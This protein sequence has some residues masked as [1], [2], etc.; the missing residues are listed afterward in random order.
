[1]MKDIHELSKKN[2]LYVLVDRVYKILPIYENLE[3]RQSLFNYIQSLLYEF[4]GLPDYMCE[5]RI[6]SDFNILYS[7]LE[8]VSNDSLFDDDNSEIVKREIFK[9]IN[10]VKRIYKNVVGEDYEYRR[11]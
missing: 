10:L 9:S 4:N 2:Y 7:T 3:H 6:S 1:M 8:E 5:I 11:T